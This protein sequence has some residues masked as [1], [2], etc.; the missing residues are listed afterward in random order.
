[1]KTI[2]RYHFKPSD[3]QNLSLAILSVDTAL[4]LLYLLRAVT[5]IVYVAG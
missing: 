4:F 5:A 3:W 2:A 1:M